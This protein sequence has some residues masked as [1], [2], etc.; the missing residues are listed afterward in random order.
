M[1]DANGEWNAPL[2]LLSTV[3][4]RGLVANLASAATKASAFDKDETTLAD[5]LATVVPV[6][7][8]AGPEDGLLREWERL[9]VTQVT[10]MVEQANPARDRTELQDMQE[11]KEKVEKRTQ[12]YSDTGGKRKAGESIELYAAQPKLR[13]SELQMAKVQA[14]QA[15][16][17]IRRRRERVAKIVAPGQNLGDKPRLHQLSEEFLRSI[18]TLSQESKRSL[19]TDGVPLSTLD[20]EALLR[21]VA[22]LDVTRHGDDPVRNDPNLITSAKARTT[23][24]LHASQNAK[25]EAELVDELQKRSESPLRRRAMP[26]YR[27]VLPS[28]LKPRD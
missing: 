9:S 10:S 23:F 12:F 8:N 18:P 25:F 5:A 1:V 6:I 22:S 3:A 21:S 20:E 17:E 24:N 15:D 4:R 27:V 19:S 14:L 7:N 28:K 2:Q 16:V 26:K 11:F 13:M